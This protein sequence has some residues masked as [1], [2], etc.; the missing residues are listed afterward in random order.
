MSALFAFS[1]FS[2]SDMKKAFNAYTE[3]V[4]PLRDVIATEVQ[5]KLSTLTFSSSTS[6]NSLA[7]S[8]LVIPFSTKFGM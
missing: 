7:L 8:I 3:Q 2:T 6:H 1:Y 4:M 5:V